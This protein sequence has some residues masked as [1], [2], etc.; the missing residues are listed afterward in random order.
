[1]CTII[2]K[3]EANE[4]KKLEL[5]IAKNKNI[6]CFRMGWAGN[7]WARAPFFIVREES[8]FGFCIGKKPAD[9]LPVYGWM[10]GWMNVR[11]LF[12]YHHHQRSRRSRCL[13]WAYDNSWIFN[14]V[15]E[16]FKWFVY[17]DNII[18]GYFV[19]ACMFVDMHF[20]FSRFF[21]LMSGCC[22]EHHR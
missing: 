4:K 20:I 11:I 8:V 2:E 18:F 7:R 22:D 19:L 14:F 13:F 21:F 9:S 6:K 12:F 5:K 17:L 10:D 1:M 3:R 15:C 16:T